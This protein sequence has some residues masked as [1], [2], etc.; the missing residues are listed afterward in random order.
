M[1]GILH[2]DNNELLGVYDQVGALNAVD[3]FLSG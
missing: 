3:V 1:A 2:E